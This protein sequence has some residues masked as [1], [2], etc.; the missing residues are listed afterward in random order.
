MTAE[1][2][3]TVRAPVPTAWYTPSRTLL[4]RK[5]LPVWPMPAG[6]RDW[7]ATVPS[8]PPRHHDAATSRAHSTV[9]SVNRM[10]LSL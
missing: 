3:T 1:L 10:Q 6:T 7:A 5:A 4:N 8:G 9:A 2:P